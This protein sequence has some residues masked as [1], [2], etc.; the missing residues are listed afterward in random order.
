MEALEIISSQYACVR[1]SEDDFAALEQIVQVMDASLDDSRD[2]VTLNVEFHQFI[3]DCADLS[4]LPSFMDRVLDQWQRLRRHYLDNVFA[5]R[6][7]G[8]PAGTLAAS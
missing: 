7:E 1:M 2:L 5:R 6:V 3:V 4:V 8:R